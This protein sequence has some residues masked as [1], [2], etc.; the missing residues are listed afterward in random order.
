MLVVIAFLTLGVRNGESVDGHRGLPRSFWVVFAS[1]TGAFGLA[2]LLAIVGSAVARLCGLRAASRR[3][4]VVGDS[5]AG[6]RL[7]SDDEEPPAMNCFTRSNLQIE[8]R[9]A[10]RSAVAR[11]LRGSRFRIRGT[12][13][14]LPYRAS[15]RC[16]SRADATLSFDRAPTRRDRDRLW[17]HD[18]IYDTHAATTNIERRMGTEFLSSEHA[19]P[20]PSRA[21]T[22]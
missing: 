14:A 3:V 16:V 19:D 21:F 12:G 20:A 2:M 5:D 4:G 9:G 17:F 18:A 10:G 22:R 6:R 8:P 11:H 15:R 1:L 7:V 13:P